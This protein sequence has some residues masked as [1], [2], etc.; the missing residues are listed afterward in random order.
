MDCE[1]LDRL[2]KDWREGN[3]D[4]WLQLKPYV[5]QSLRRAR[6]A[7]RLP[8]EHMDAV[9]NL[10]CLRLEMAPEEELRDFPGDR[11]WEFYAAL[12]RAFIVELLRKGINEAAGRKVSLASEVC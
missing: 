11:Y 9:R 4:A 8:A 1:E 6:P 2:F 12:T 5:V 3:K 10:L 7:L